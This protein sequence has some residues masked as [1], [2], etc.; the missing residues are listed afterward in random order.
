MDFR[1]FLI[2]ANFSYY[3]LQYVWCISFKFTFLD[4]LNNRGI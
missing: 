1:V 4:P 3:L 2:E